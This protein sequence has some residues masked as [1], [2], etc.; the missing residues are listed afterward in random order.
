M[1]LSS[2]ANTGVLLKKKV[3]KKDVFISYNSYNYVI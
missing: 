2:V 3:K 1:K